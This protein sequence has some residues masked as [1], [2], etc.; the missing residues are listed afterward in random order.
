MK[1]RVTSEFIDKLPSGVDRALLRI[2]YFHI[3]RDRAVS[4]LQLLSSVRDLG[5]KIDD[6]HLRFQINQ[7]RKSGILICSTGGK[8]GGY[9]IASS[10][11]EI[12]DFL[13][14]EIR[15]RIADLSEQDRAMTTS[16]HKSFGV[17]QFT[18]F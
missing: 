15:A 5:F 4:R 12:D 16:A 11:D 13:N 6:R 2:L 3:G 7:L 9:W 10:R 18:L 8:N 14:Q 1:S 17:R